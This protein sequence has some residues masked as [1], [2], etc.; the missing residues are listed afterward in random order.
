MNEASLHNSGSVQLEPVSPTGSIA[1]RAGS[2]PGGF[3][4]IANTLTLTNWRLLS[5]LRRS[6]PGARC[7]RPGE[8]DV[9]V[10]PARA[11]ARLDISRDVDGLEDG[12]RRFAGSSARSP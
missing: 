2:L 12:L 4:L 6:V 1:P 9:I 3:A 7:V 8:L 10:R 5:A 11:L